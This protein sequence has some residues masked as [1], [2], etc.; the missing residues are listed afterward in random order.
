MTEEAKLQRLFSTFPNAAAGLGL[1]LLR[2]TIGITVIAQ[3]GLLLFEGSHQTIWVWFLELL[4]MVV[5]TSLLLGFLTPLAS[6]TVFLGGLIFIFSPFSTTNPNFLVIV[7]LIIISVSTTLLG[8]GAYSLDARIF[9]RRE[10][11]I[12]DRVLKS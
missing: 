8:P 11:I 2:F 1:L 3:S 5:G 7:Y 6:L 12:P 10:I 9:G 4:A